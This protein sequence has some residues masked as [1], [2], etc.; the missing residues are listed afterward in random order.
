M[1]LTYYFEDNQQGVRE[2][3]PSQPNLT[4]RFDPRIPTGNA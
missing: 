1:L 2:T 3:V 4:L